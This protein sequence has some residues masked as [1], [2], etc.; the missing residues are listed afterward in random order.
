MGLARGFA[1]A[2]DASRQVDRDD[3][4][5]FVEQRLPYGQEVAD[6]RLRCRGQV[7]VGAQ[8]F[9]ERVKR[10]QVDLALGVVLPTDVQADLADAFFV[11]ELAR[12]VVGG[13]GYDSDGS[14]ATRRTLPHGQ[15]CL[16][17][18]CACPRL[19]RMRA[20]SAGL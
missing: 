16:R 12:Q 6:R 14:H 7:R 3:V 13:I 15:A 4:L 8:A 5:A 17:A 2:R 20:A 18:A 1:S 9:V 11:R 10:L 19:A